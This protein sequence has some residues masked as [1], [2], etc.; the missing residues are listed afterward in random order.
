MH[1][2]PLLCIR[3]DDDMNLRLYEERHAGVLFKLIDQNRAYLRV[4]MPWLDYEQSAEDSKA[5]IRE[6]LRQ[7]A[8]NEGFQ[9]GIWYQGQLIGGIG[10]H[11]VNW[12][13]RKVEIGYWLAEA[14]QGKGLMTKACRT[15]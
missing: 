13:T 1:N 7:F 8:E 11:A 12:I 10:Y 5:F 14:F 3:I 6:S 2:K 4:W 15:L 9:T